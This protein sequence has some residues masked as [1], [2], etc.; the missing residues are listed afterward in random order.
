[1]L[2]AV[3]AAACG[4]GG[5]SVTGVNQPA[6]PAPDGSATYTGGVLSVKLALLPAL[7]ASNGHQVLGLSDGSRRADVVIINLGGSYRAFSSICT[8]EGCTVSGFTGQR[9]VCPCHGSEFNTSGSPVVGPATAALR[10]YAVTFN[11]VTQ[12]LSILV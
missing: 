2:T 9:M 8:H 1:M 6:S 4:G 3:L 10:E 7:T 12:T 11:S 5:D